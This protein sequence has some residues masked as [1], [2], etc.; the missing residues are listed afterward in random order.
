MGLSYSERQ[1]EVS[2]YDSDELL[3][4]LRSRKAVLKPVKNFTSQ[5]WRLQ[6]N[7]ADSTIY[8]ALQGKLSLSWVVE[9]LGDLE[10][11]VQEHPREFCTPPEI[12]DEWSEAR[13]VMGE[14]ASAPWWYETLN[15]SDLT[16]ETTFRS[17]MSRDTPPRPWFEIRERAVAWRVRVLRGLDAWEY[18]YRVWK[19]SYLMDFRH[20][21]AQSWVKDALDRFGEDVALEVFTIIRRHGADDYVK[22][23]HCFDP[24]QPE[25]AFLTWEDY[26]R[27]GDYDPRP[28]FDDM[29]ASGFPDYI[30]NVPQTQEPELRVVDKEWVTDDYVAYSVDTEFRVTFEWD[31]L[32]RQLISNPV[33]VR[34]KVWFDPKYAEDGERVHTHRTGFENKRVLVKEPDEDGNFEEWGYDRVEKRVEYIERWRAVDEYDT[35]WV[36]AVDAAIMKAGANDENASTP[37]SSHPPI[38]QPTPERP[39]RDYT[40][41]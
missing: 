23:Y 35:T 24:A 4:T 16:K 26:T 17:Q 31:D 36:D 32:K 18:R 7:L 28:E 27:L 9:S 29:V 22:T 2:F 20:A 34:K 40:R 21:L 15:I 13:V 25:R 33:P 10:S 39:V 19:N 37:N 12:P 8:Q 6:G 41:D 14:Y 5:H 38:E 11:Y 1:E 3:R 30:E